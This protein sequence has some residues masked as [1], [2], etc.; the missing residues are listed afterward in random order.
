MF[1]AHCLGKAE[2]GYGRKGQRRKANEQ[3]DADRAVRIKS[4][5]RDQK[6][7]SELSS[8][9]ADETPEDRNRSTTEERCQRAV[10]GVK[11]VAVARLDHR[12]LHRPKQVARPPGQIDPQ[13]SC[14][15]GDR[16]AG[17]GDTRLAPFQGGA[18]TRVRA[19]T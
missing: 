12:S 15:H 19:H 16:V 4:K 3:V 6:G 10:Y 2:P 13:A 14:L 5:D 11:P 8:A 1:Q 9:Q 7:Q 18:V 17:H